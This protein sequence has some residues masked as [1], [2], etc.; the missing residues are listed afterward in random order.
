M[1]KHCKI[2]ELAMYLPLPYAGGVFAEM[3]ARVTKIESPKG[4]DPLKALDHSV[5]NYLNAKKEVVY[6]D[7]KNTDDIKKAYDIISKSDVVLNGF[8]RGFLEK[9][10]L[11]YETL[12]NENPGLIYVSLAGYEKGLKDEDKV[13]HDLNFV[14]LSGIIHNFAE[15]G[16]LF[17]FQ[18]ADMAGALWSVIG[19]LYML[20]KRR[21]SGIGGELDLSL[22]RSLV[23]FFPFFYGAGKGEG[24]ERGTFTGNF[25]CY[26]V[27]ETKD[28][29]KI[30]FG[31]IEKKFFQR[32]LDILGIAYDE[33]SLYSL[34]YQEELINNVKKAVKGKD[35]DY[36]ITVFEKENICITPILSKEEFYNY[37][38]FQGIDKDRLRDF[39]F[40]PIKD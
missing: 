32:A 35:Y 28:K 36:L 25:A 9:A 20:E 15:E 6:L 27:Y 7:L 13:G 11:D 10:G 2:V 12:K 26:N 16:K 37:L 4:G 21:V 34:D 17:P 14:S 18:L 22:F 5:Y 31:C 8:R 1:L 39:L 33:S 40:S 38:E 3:G 23:S 29:K 24:V 19:V 30:A